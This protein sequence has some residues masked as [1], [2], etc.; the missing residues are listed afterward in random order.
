MGTIMD[1]NGM[2]LTEQERL[3]RDDKIHRR[4]VKKKIFKTKIITMV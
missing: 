3:R 1:T 2:D 4:T